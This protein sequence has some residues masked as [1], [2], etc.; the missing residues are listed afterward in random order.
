MQEILLVQHM[1]H[2]IGYKNHRNTCGCNIRVQLEN[3][4]L[5]FAARANNLSHLQTV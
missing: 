5:Y 2:L 1:K 3:K 4:V